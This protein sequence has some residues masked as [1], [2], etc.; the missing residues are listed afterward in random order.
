[1]SDSTPD[2]LNVSHSE[3]DFS[4]V[5]D[6]LPPNLSRSQRTH[7]MAQLEGQQ[8]GQRSAVFTFYSKPEFVEEISQ[9]T[10]WRAISGPGESLCDNSFVYK[11]Q[12]CC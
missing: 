3:H 7:M 10:K 6:H 5:N 2:W 8:Q 4:M 1:M 12:L 9:K 11:L